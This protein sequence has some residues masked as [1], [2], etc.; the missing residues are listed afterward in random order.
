[1]QISGWWQIF[2]VGAFGGLLIEI[3]RLWKIRESEKL[4]DYYGKALYWYITLA[5]VVAGGVLAVLY[6][7]EGERQALMVLNIGA[8]AP[9]LI[10]ALATPKSVQSDNR[11]ERGSGAPVPAA[12]NEGPSVRRFLSFGG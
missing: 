12:Q 7:F 2:A 9:A 1:M 8:S 6:G 4:P 5:M 3:L 11:Q 10:G